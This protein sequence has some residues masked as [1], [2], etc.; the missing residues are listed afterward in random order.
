M[1]LS[2]IRDRSAR[3]YA[4]TRRI[5]EDRFDGP[6]YIIYGLRIKENCPSWA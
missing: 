4:N 6:Y 2:K 3:L 1:T 5:A